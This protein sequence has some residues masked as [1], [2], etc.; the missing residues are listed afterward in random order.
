[1]ND[2]K[3]KGRDLI[4]MGWKP[5]PAIGETVRISAEM[6]D[7]GVDSDTIKRQINAIQ[8][9][10]KAYEDDA[11]WGDVA[12][13]LLKQQ[14]RAIQPQLRSEPAPLR[15]WGR[16]LID[17]DSFKQINDAARLPVTLRVALMPDAH[18][19][20]GLPIGGIAALEGAIAPYMVGVDIGCRMHATIFKR[21]PIHLKQKPALYEQLLM[22]HTFFG[23]KAPPRSERNQHPILDDPRWEML[24][25]QFNN[26][27]DL[28][29]EQLGT[30]GG[31]NHFVEWA[32]LTVLD[33]NPMDLEP[34]E[35]IALVSH[36]GSRGVGF[37]LAN[38]YSSMAENMAF[39]LP[40]Q[41]RKL[42]YLDY[43]R[44]EGQEYEV[45]MT[46]AGD[47][48]RANHEVIHERISTALGRDVVAA[49]L[50]NHHN[51]AWRVMREDGTPIFI[52][53]KGSTPA[54]QGA[55]GI[56]PGSMAAPGFFVIGR[57]YDDDHILEHPSLN[58]AAHGSGRQLGRKQAIRS[59][60]SK[61]VRNSL[62]KKGVTLLGGGLDEAP[63]AYKDSRQVIA[64][65]A[66]L[67]EVW[68]EFRPKIVRMAD[69]GGRSLGK[70]MGDKGWG[71]RG[72]RK[73]KRRR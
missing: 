51:Y 28:G 1:M 13:I 46:L 58:S 67:V 20:Y 12:G 55:L 39:F 64:A 47:F 54:T 57:C 65:Q 73:K 8:S 62:E 42:G 16:E 60:D 3:I 40:K 48:A 38:H 4:E 59:L 17:E 9:D 37:K 41:M 14:A 34:G 7:Q 44:G 66:D 61:Q 32:E 25:R 35:Y 15:V 49:T 53:R 70:P 31:G 43:K 29:E 27:K 2:E 23:H 33:N 18:I 26:L 36:S 24:P 10:P 63:D 45:A 72:R 19:G 52:H 50:Q 6:S 69:D 71:S 56:I 21:N 5:G 30:S 68:A 22:E 11:V